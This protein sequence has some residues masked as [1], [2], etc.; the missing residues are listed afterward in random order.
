MSCLGGL[1]LSGWSLGSCFWKRTTKDIQFW[2]LGP[3]EVPPW[4]LERFG[5]V[6][7]PRSPPLRVYLGK[8]Q[9][10]RFFPEVA[11]SQA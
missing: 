1:Q 7:G 2:G 8:G 4:A 9:E 10:T 6:W 11:F 3:E 5:R